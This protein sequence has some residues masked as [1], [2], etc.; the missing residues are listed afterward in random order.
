MTGAANAQTFRLSGFLSVRGVYTQSRQ[1][2]WVDGGFGRLETNQ[3]W[4]NV[5]VAQLGADWTPAPWIDVH[6]SAQARSKGSGLVD[7]FIALRKDFA[8]DRI[9]LRAGQFFL[10]T[11]RENRENLWTSPYTINFSALNT[12]IAEEVRPIGGELEWRHELPGL[13]AITVAGGAFRNN[14]TM[15]ALLGWRGWSIGNRLSVYNE[16]LPLPPLFSLRE[17]RFFADQRHDGTKPFESD[18]DKRAGYTARIRYQRPERGSI[19]F[20]RVDNRGDRHEYRGE[21]AW[22]TRFNVVSADVMN[23]RGTTLAAEDCWGKTGMGFPPGAVVDLT[24]YAAYVLASQTA[25]RNRFTARFDVFRTKDKDHSIAETNSES[26]RA[27]TLAYFYEWRPSTRFGIEF[28]NITGDRV[29]AAESGFDPNMDARSWTLEMR[30][31][32]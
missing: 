9:Q 25:G 15:G 24:Y 5:D 20:A 3:G 1:T 19:Q 28:A 4:K 17:P 11:S 14:D 21:Y 23:D 31:K 13:D 16:G 27:W 30:Y 32:F 22:Q 29:A 7:A 26:G 12:W 8:H 6:A 2:S 18:L 10:G